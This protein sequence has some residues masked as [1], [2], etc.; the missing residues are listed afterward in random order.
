MRAY[1][2]RQ[3]DLIRSLDFETCPGEG[4]CSET[5]VIFLTLRDE[6]DMPI[7]QICEGCRFLPTK[8]GQ[9][10]A[11]LYRAIVTANEL[12]AIKQSGGTF[13][14]PD[15]FSAFEWTCLTALQAGR[16]ESEANSVRE[17]NRA[18]EQQS[19]RSRLD[20]SRRR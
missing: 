14:Y 20:Q 6:P 2:T 1:F 17:R 19:E 10:P 7:E 15:T 5:G 9:E 8:P 12:D 18:A 3:L 16:A 13:A 11:H 4:D